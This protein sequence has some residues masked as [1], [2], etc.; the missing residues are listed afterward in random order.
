MSDQS[1]SGRVAQINVNPAGGVPKH[2]VPRV[3]VTANGVRGDRQRDR[4]FHGD[5]TRGVSLFSLE[6][7]EALQVEGH[8]ITPGSTGENLTIAGLDWSALQIGDRLRVGARGDRDHWRCRAAQQH[9]RFVHG[10]R[11]HAHLV[12]AAPRLEP[13]VCTG[14]R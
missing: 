12:Q 10:R 9:R 14:N 5:P 1:H 7:I 8:S 11:V 13:P 2:A 6:R 3:E 4:R